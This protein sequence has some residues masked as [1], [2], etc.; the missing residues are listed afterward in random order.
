MGNKKAS[1][2]GDGWLEFA[3]KGEQVRCRGNICEVGSK[4]FT[5]KDEAL[6][7]IDFFR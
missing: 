3:Y 7:Y 5:T 6:A 4:R 2:A 1:K